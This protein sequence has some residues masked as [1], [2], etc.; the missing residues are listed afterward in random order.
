MGIAIHNVSTSAD[1]HSADGEDLV[2]VLKQ[3]AS[4]ILGTSV[5]LADL[6]RGVPLFVASHDVSRRCRGTRV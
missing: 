1:S 5:Q 6:V 4:G 2:S 3:S